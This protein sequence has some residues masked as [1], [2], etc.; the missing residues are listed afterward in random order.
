MSRGISGGKEVIKFAKRA[1]AFKLVYHL[2]TRERLNSLSPN[3]HIQILQTDL[4]TFL[5]GLVER[6]R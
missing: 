2:K 1:I 3:F 6:I 4:L 5:Y